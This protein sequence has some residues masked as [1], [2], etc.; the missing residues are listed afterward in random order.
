[1]RNTKTEFIEWEEPTFFDNS[2]TE[3]IVQKS[4][5]PGI[6]GEGLHKAVY[7]AFDKYGNNASCSINITVKGSVICY[8]GNLYF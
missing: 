7:T 6:L 2:N 5:S 8:L 4:L 1:M 3:V